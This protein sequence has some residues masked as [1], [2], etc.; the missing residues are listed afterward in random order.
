MT[1]A[2]LLR[3]CYP[4]SVMDKTINGCHIRV[5]AD[6][7]YI[8]MYG[9]KYRTGDLYCIIKD[10]FVEDRYIIRDDVA[11]TQPTYI[12][13]IFYIISLTS[14]F[15]AGFINGG[16]NTAGNDDINYI[17][18]TKYNGH[19]YVD[20]LELYVGLRIREYRNLPELAG[21]K[22][23]SYAGLPRALRIHSHNLR[24]FPRIVYGT[25][26]SCIAICDNKI[27][28][29]TNDRVISNDEHYY[30]HAKY[31]RFYIHTYRQKFVYYG[32]HRSIESY[33]CNN[34]LDDDVLI[35]LRKAFADPNVTC[36]GAALTCMDDLYEYMYGM[37]HIKYDP[38]TCDYRSDI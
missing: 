18:Y 26:D 23:V 27:L 32:F 6:V 1:F 19:L 15:M 22:F 38:D 25:S 20:M 34:I 30:Y 4:L 9:Y 11:V 28:Y 16:I 2:E 37:F 36:L 24:I 17:N 3:S 33:Y 21:I 14:E 7:P 35:N 5:V 13:K 29:V 8:S 12:A 10:E 31:E